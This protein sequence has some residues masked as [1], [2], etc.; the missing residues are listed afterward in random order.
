MFLFFIA[1]KVRINIDFQAAEC[2]FFLNIANAKAV[3]GVEWFSGDFGGMTTRRIIK[4]HKNI[5]FNE[6]TAISIQNKG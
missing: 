4:G 2:G 6:G 5:L 1:A 3:P